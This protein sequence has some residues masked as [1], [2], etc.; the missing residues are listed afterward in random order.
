MQLWDF[1][2]SKVLHTINVDSP[3]IILQFRVESELLA[4]VS[5]DMCIRVIDI[6]TRKIVREFWGHRN[7]VT[8]IVCVNF[9]RF[10]LLLIYD[11]HHRLC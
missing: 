11:A 4:I 9:L 2:T 7:R 1:H 3:I 6:E 5:D 10:G 8:D